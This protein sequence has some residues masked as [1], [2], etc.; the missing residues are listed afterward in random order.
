[1]GGK[2]QTDFGDV[3]AS[4][5]EENAGVVRDQLYANRPNQYTP[6]GYSNWQQDESVDANGNPITNWTQTQGLTPELQD[7]L[8]KQIAIQGGRS[9]IAGML[10][11]RMGAEFGQTMDWRGLNPMGQ[12]PTAQY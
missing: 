10:T 2:S 11:G 12:R 5:G 9:D 3:A 6:W 4:Q 7:I 1:M 8:N